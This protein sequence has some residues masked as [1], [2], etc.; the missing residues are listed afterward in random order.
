MNYLVLSNSISPAGD[1]DCHGG[2]TCYN[3]CPSQSACVAKCASYN[4]CSR[5]FPGCIAYM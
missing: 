1:V 4:T 3:F 5:N 2:F